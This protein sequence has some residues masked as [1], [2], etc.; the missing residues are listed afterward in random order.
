[1]SPRT[2]S[3]AGLGW[4]ARRTLTWQDLMMNPL[5]VGLNYLSIPSIK[6]VEKEELKE[7][8]LV[9]P[10][11]NTQKYHNQYWGIPKRASTETGDRSVSQALARSNQIKAYS[12]DT[13]RSVEDVR[14]IV[15]K[16]LE[17]TFNTDGKVTSKGVATNNANAS[18]SKLLD[19]PVE[20]G[21]TKWVGTNST[22]TD[23]YGN[24]IAPNINIP[25]STQVEAN[26]N[27]IKGSIT[28]KVEDKTNT[29]PASTSKTSK[30]DY[31]KP[32]NNRFLRMD[33]LDYNQQK[34]LINQGL[35][36][37]PDGNQ[38]WM[39][40]DGKMFT[41]LSET[42]GGESGLPA[43]KADQM[44]KLDAAKA[45]QGPSAGAVMGTIGKVMQMV[46]KPEEPT[47]KPTEVDTGSKSDKVSSMFNK[48]I[49]D[50]DGLGWYGSL[51]NYWNA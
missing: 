4:R 8:G 51:Q 33:K 21:R 30:V 38:S 26:N 47:L 45:S 14:A 9:Q 25:Q 13:G 16:G 31:S 11:K 39:K 42:F 6:D 5:G 27:Q 20:P 41:N 17:T 24:T 22:W 32:E 15:G 28:P 49:R 1:M 3:Q 18:K 46:D 48:A 12:E 43:W 23:R 34:D 50:P 44:M 35:V 7:G 40:H 36:Q 10:K 37:T 29:T 2:R 19:I